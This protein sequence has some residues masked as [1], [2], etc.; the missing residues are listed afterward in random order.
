MVESPLKPNDGI[1]SEAASKE[2][3][4]ESEEEESKNSEDLL[5]DIMNED[6]DESS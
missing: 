6:S 5:A 2:E 3:E 4:S 1:S